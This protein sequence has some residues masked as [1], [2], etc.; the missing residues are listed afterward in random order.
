M[1]S[2]DKISKILYN[3]INYK[4][5]VMKHF[6]KGKEY[7]EIPW[8]RAIKRPI[9]IRIYQMDDDFIVETLEGKMKG[10]KGD[11][12]MSGVHGELYPCDK[13]IFERTYDIQ[14]EDIDE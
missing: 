3:T 1:S 4:G 9:P 14:K 5:A 8:K 2:L 6:I 7:P 11:Y 12:L 13:D 10:K